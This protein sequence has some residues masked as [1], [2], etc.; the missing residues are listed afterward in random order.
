MSRAVLLCP[1]WL[2]YDSKTE[3]ILRL[4]NSASHVLTYSFLGFPTVHTLLWISLGMKAA[5]GLGS[6]KSQVAAK[7]H[8]MKKVPCLRSR[9]GG[10]AF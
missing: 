2:L 5:E 6:L 4:I 10:E 1:V 3:S 7:T 8:D 9:R